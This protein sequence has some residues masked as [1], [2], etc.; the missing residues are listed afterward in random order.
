MTKK[1][2]IKAKSCDYIDD[3]CI[4]LTSVNHSKGMNQ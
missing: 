1:I 4:F 2:N 3:M